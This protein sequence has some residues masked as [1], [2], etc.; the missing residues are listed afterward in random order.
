MKK[1]LK[2]LLAIVAILII[3]MFLMGKAYHFEKSIVINAP[4]EKVYAQINSTKAINQWNPWMKLDPNLKVTY[5]GNPGQIGDKYCWEGNDEVGSGCQEIT[6]L[7]P[8]Q[9]Q[10]TKMI[11]YKPFESDATSNIILTP[12]GNS[13]KVTWDMDCELD[14]PMNLMKLFMDGQMDKSYGDG[15][16]ALKAISE[17]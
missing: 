8:N 11:F 15:L 3:V 2:I 16:N 5:S 10:S 4:V 14:Y 9:K 7:V 6:A 1:F 13:T 17:K 12:E